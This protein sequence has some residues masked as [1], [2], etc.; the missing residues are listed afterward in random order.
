[1]SNPPQTTSSIKAMCLLCVW[2]F[3]TSSMST[4]VSY[5]LAGIA[6]SSATHIG[7]HRP[8][9]L[10]DFSRIKCRLGPKELSEAATAWSA[11][12]IAAER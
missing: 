3:P 12:Y 6:I 4:D 10:Q 9:L 8:E 7:L 5:T 11:C 1:M 2:P